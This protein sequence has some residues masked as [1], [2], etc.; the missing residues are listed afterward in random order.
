MILTGL[1]LSE[2]LGFGQTML[3]KFKFR[4]DELEAPMRC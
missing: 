1:S 3:A 2:R 4:T